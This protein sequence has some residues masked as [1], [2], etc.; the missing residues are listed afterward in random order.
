MAA[1]AS[2]VLVGLFVCFCKYFIITKLAQRKEAER[3]RRPLLSRR[4][5]FED[6]IAPGH[7]SGY[8]N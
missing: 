4:E 7:N 6:A 2:L 3:E 1:A 8:T 5:R